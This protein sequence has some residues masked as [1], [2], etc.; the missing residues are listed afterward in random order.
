MSEAADGAEAFRRLLADRPDLAILDVA[1]PV[2]DGLAVCRAARAEPSLAGLGII[3]LSAYANADAALA[4]G[5]DR[6]LRKPFSPLELLATIEEVLAL[7]GPRPRAARPGGRCRP[8]RSDRL[9]VDGGQHDEGARQAAPRCGA[10]RRAARRSRS[11]RTRPGPSSTTPWPSSTTAHPDA[12]LERRVQHLPEQAEA[13]GRRA[14]ADL[15][16]DLVP[17]RPVHEAREPRR[18][19]AHA[20]HRPLAGCRTRARRRAAATSE[21]AHASTPPPALR[22]PRT[23][24][25]PGPASVPRRRSRSSSFDH[26]R[27]RRK[28]EGRRPGAW[29]GR[30]SPTSSQPGSSA[31]C[32]RAALVAPVTPPRAAAAPRRPSTAPPGRRASRPPPAGP[33]RCACASAPARAPGAS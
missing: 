22:R 9:E 11:A 17:R 14:G 16:V 26:R 7:R 12:R 6:H 29:V 3:V 10:S 19:G 27:D 21:A 18:D 31:S 24:A 28:V 13:A 2:M 4:A 1:M 33:P 32:A 15:E 5:A 25:L 30:A 23:S 20:E 8:A